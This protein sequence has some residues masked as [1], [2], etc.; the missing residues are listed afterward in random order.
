MVTRATTLIDTANKS[1]LL[2]MC[3]ISSGSDMNGL[4]C[5]GV[6]R[7]A[8]VSEFKVVMMIN[9]LEMRHDV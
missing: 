3:G 8:S 2:S 4:Y 7:Y 5:R 1:I 6:C 9:E